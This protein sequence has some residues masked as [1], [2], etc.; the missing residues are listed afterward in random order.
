MTNQSG[1]SKAAGFLVAVFVSFLWVSESRGDGRGD[2][3]V[4][5]TAIESDRGKIAIALF[6]SEATYNSRE[7]P[8]REERLAISNR[9]AVWR[10]TDIPFANY[11]LMLYHDENGNGEFD[12]NF[13]GIPLEQ[14]G[15][16][17]NAVA[18]FAPPAYEKATFRLTRDEQEHVVTLTGDGDQSSCLECPDR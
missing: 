1:L 11:A 10:I 4:R 13:I 7:N 3:I 12:Q 9:E 8:F 18:W 17:N 15:F 14:Y 2:L 6:D 5:V 16:S